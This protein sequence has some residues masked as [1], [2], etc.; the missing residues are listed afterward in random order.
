MI[1]KFVAHSSPPKHFSVTYLKSMVLR[2]SFTDNY[3][4]NSNYTVI[5]VV[6]G[7]HKSKGIR[8]WETIYAKEIMTNTITPRLK[9]S[10]RHCPFDTKR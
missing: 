4:L 1:Y 6:R 9:L 10:V 2:A 3:S 8:Q 7:T 5:L